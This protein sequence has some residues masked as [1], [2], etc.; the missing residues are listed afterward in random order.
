MWRYW[1]IWSVAL[2]FWFANAHAA[3]PRQWSARSGAGANTLV[4]L[5]TSEG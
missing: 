3:E 4:E 1:L 5:Y 2:S